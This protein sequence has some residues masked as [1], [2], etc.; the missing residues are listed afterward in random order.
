MEIFIGMLCLIA[1]FAIYVFF[2][3]KFLKSDENYLDSLF[4]KDPNFKIYFA[5]HLDKWKVI[6]DKNR[7]IEYIWDDYQG[8]LATLDI[9]AKR[10]KVLQS[11]KEGFAES[12]LTN[13]TKEE[14]KH[15][16]V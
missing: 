9:K 10:A 7:R 3:E 4:K 11:L 12:E 1:F 2:Y 13:K 15:F 14:M 6:N 8:E 5:N 16:E